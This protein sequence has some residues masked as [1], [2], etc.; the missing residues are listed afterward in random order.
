MPRMHRIIHLLMII[1]AVLTLPHNL[2]SQVRDPVVR[3]DTPNIVIPFNLV[4]KLIII[5]GS[6]D[7]TSGNFILDTG[8]PG[9]VLN[10]TYFRDYP[11]HVPHNTTSSH[12]NGNGEQTEQTTIP[13]FTLGAMHYY[14]TQAD[15]LPLGHLEEARGIKILGLIGVSFFKECE[16]LIDYQKNEIHLRHIARN[17]IKT[18][19]NHIL[20]DASKFHA[21]PI[22]LK[23]NKIL[24]NSTI[25]KRKLK[26]AIDYAAETSILDA[27]LPARVLDSV[28]INGR[29]LLTGAGAL[30][31]EALS[32]LLSGLQISGHPITTLP[33]IITRLE[34]TCFGGMDCVNGVLGYDYLSRGIVAINFRKRILYI[35]K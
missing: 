9:L 20:S 5:Q 28:E 4:G 27:A 25:G 29:I 24:V 11:I 35:A 18:Y 14:R 22:E 30:K 26:L 6:A 3:S 31:V 23:D 8:S 7:S 33:V 32:G 21:W 15:L 13:H 34:N 12:I 10:N 1:G 17:E 2:H 16:L 19:N